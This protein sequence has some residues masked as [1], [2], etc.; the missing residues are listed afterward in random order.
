[1]TNVGLYS[2]NV[3]IELNTDQKCV[4]PVV[5]VN[6]KA[7]K[8]QIVHAVEMA[9]FALE[10]ITVGLVTDNIKIPEPLNEISGYVYKDND[11]IENNK[12]TGVDHTY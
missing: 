12:Q 7:T 8:D 2:G 3:I 5:K 10:Q 9:R 1:V 4:K 6:E 11:F